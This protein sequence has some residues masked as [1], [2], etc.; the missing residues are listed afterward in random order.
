M[1]NGTETRELIERKTNNNLKT[2]F[3]NKTF[4][5]QNAAEK[6]RVT[7]MKLYI[8][9]IDHVNCDD[10]KREKQQCLKALS[11]GRNIRMELI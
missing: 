6:N 4:F 10:S 1:S 9:A 3:E 5:G 8:C 7:Q 11:S 2:R